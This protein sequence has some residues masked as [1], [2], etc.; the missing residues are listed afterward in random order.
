LSV[1][2]KHWDGEGMTFIFVANG[3][4]A[5]E[6]LEELANGE[7]FVVPSPASMFLRTLVAAKAADESWR[8]GP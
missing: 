6:H 5:I 1:Q 4:G 7:R 2:T 3:S 8:H